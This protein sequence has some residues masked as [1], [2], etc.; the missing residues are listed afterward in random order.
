MKANEVIGLLYSCVAGSAHVEVHVFN[1]T[2]REGHAMELIA[3]V[4]IDPA[5]NVIGV[6]GMT[7]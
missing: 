4:V 5:K 3:T 2:S 7:A 6:H 1:I